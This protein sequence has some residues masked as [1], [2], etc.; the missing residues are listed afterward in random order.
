LCAT[1]TYKFVFEEKEEKD[2]AKVEIEVVEEDATDS[3]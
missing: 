3:A 2:P 1:A